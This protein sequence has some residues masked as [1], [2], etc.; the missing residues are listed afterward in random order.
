M[1]GS[2]ELYGTTH[3]A[4]NG[5]GAVFRLKQRRGTAPQPS[6]APWTSTAARSSPCARRHARTGQGGTNTPNTEAVEAIFAR[7]GAPIGAMPFGGNYF[8]SVWRNPPEP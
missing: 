3:A 4:E 8:R 1:D 5:T 2:S 6:A 7:S